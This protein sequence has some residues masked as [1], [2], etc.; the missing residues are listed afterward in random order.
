M[1]A[2]DHSVKLWIYDFCFLLS[3]LF[4]ADTRFLAM[5]QAQDIGAV[6]EEDK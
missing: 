5:D 3:G 4:I 2:N 1:A 6:L